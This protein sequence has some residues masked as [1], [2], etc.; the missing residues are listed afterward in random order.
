MLFY[1]GGTTRLT[2]ASTGAATF[3]SSVTATSFIPSGSSVPTNGMYLSAANTLNFATNSGN[4]LSISST[5]AATF[6]S[7]I[8]TTAG[9]IGVS[10]APFVN[11][12]SNGSIDLL[13]GAGLFGY[14]NGTYLS[15]NLYYNTAFTYKATAGASLYNQDNTGAHLWYTV[16]SGTINTTATLTERMRITSGG[17]VGIGTTSPSEKLEVSGTGKFTTGV[18]YN[19]L[20]PTTSTTTSTTTLNIVLPGTGD[21]Y[22]ITDQQVDLSVASPTGTFVNGQKLLI[23]IKDNG[24]ARAI[25]WTTGASGAYRASTDMP[26]PTTTIINKTMYLGFIWNGNDS[27]WDMIAF[28]NNF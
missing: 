17:N 6:S 11:T 26:L 14:L 22:T 10:V 13:N 24:T 8:K 21:T 7:D 3:S 27:R 2:I 23:R 18:N 5:G 12:L 15:N 4:R 19:V 20:I 1:T 25:T 16:P 9:K 28:L